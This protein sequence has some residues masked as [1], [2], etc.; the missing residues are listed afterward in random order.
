MSEPDRPAWLLNENIPAPSVE[1]LRVMGWD[2][3]AISESHASITDAAVLALARAERRWLATFDR[4]YGELIYRRQLPAPPL[5]LL[6]RVTSY[7]PEEPAEWI[8]R[9]YTSGQLLPE[10]FHIFAGDTIRRRPL[11][12]VTPG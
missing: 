9:L 11:L 3:L 5:V 8:D 6:F 10:C 7:R 1:R 12:P 2:A 4:D